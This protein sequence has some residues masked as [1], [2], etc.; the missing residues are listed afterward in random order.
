MTLQNIPIIAVIPA[1]GG[2]K[3]ITLKNIDGRK[4]LEELD[5]SPH[6][7]PQNLSIIEFCKIAKKSFEFNS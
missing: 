5:I 6:L 2:S 1:R 3:G 4:I 7:R